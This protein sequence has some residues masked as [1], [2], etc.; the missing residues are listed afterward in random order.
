VEVAAKEEL[1]VQHAA[2]EAAL[3]AA[4]EQL[5]QQAAGT[6]RTEADALSLRRQAEELWAQARQEAQALL[7]ARASFE[8]T[9]AQ[10]GRP[11]A[12]QLAGAG[13]LRRC[14]AWPGWLLAWVL[15]GAAAAAGL[16]QVRSELQ[17][18]EEVLVQKEQQLLA[19]EQQLLGSRA[20]ASD[21]VSELQAAAREV[22]RQ[23]RLAEAEQQ[24]LQQVLHELQQQVAIM[25]QEVSKWKQVGAAPLRCL[26]AA[27]QRRAG[28]A[29]HHAFA[30]PPAT[31]S[32]RPTASNQPS[33]PASPSCSPWLWQPQVSRGQPCSRGSQAG[34]A[35]GPV[36]TATPPLPMCAGAPAVRAGRQG[37]GALGAAGRS[38]GP[39]GGAARA[40]AVR[41]AGGG[42][43]PHRAGPGPGAGAGCAG[44][45]RVVRGEAGG[46]PPLGPG[47]APLGGCLFLAVC[48]IRRWAPTWSVCQRRSPGLPPL[49]PQA[50]Q[51]ALQLEREQLA[52]ERQAMQCDLDAVLARQQERVQSWEAQVEAAEGELLGRRAAAQAEE[53]RW[54]AGRR[55]AH[56]AAAAW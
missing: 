29:S 45:Q 51:Q 20:R 44:A 56:L 37:L 2:R 15:M 40:A 8:D 4:E 6:Q 9:K 32:L 27:H 48:S 25:E 16:P 53:G 19:F 26:A 52:V 31:T 11:A 18:Q 42:A 10:V 30:Q 38:G 14:S 43:G 55:P 5:E 46:W 49:R 33:I 54:G 12:G 21:E 3:R 7:E 41:R 39:R 1:A 50:Q 36:P 13:L 17:Q 35:G 22:Q 28:L 24:Q 23:L 34:A 47:R